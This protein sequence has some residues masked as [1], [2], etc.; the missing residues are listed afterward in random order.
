[1][2]TLN[3][4][5]TFRKG[6]K[7]C[8][9]IAIEKLFSS[10]KSFYCSPVKV[11]LLKSLSTALPSVKVLITVPKKYLRRA[12]DRNRIKR[13][14][15]EAYRIKKYE[16]FQHLNLKESEYTIAFIF[17]GKKLVSYSE[18]IDVMG[19]IIEQIALLEQRTPND[20]AE[21]SSITI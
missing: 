4:R 2:E 9:K 3:Q 8:S 6:E 7:L 16:L 18:V 20:S 14:L 21:I 15:R 17:T 12:T 19:R 11:L 13:L 10:G 1:M 5:F